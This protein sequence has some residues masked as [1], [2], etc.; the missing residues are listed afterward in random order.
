MNKIPHPQTAKG[1]A[2]VTPFIQL[3][4]IPSTTRYLP[5]EVAHDANYGA[6]VSSLHTMR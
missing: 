2:Q 5:L 6:W 1:E 4:A 3:K